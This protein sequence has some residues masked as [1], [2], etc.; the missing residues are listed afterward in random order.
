MNAPLPDR[1]PADIALYRSLFCRVSDAYGEMLS[2]GPYA[3]RS[4]PS[5]QDIQAHLAGTRLLGFYLVDKNG[6]ADKGIV[7]VDVPKDRLDDTVA[8]K[9]AGG[10]DRAN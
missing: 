8:W 7:D 6:C 2:S 10:K 3:H 9:E 4:C 1:T 5:D